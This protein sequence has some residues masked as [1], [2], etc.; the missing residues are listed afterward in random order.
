MELRRRAVLGLGLAVGGLAAAATAAQAAD[1]SP[2]AFELQGDP[3]RYREA[4]DDIRAYAA[5]HMAAYSLPGLTLTV[6]AP[7]GLTAFM[8][9]GYADVDRRT[10]VGP[11]QLFQIGSISKSFTALCIFRLMEAGKLKLSDDVGPLLPGVPLPAGATITVQHLL[12]H[13]SGLADDP[14]AWPRGGDQQLWRGYAPGSHW[15]YSNLGFA[16]LSTIVARLSGQPFPDALRALVLTPLGMTATKPAIL[17]ADRGLYATGY[18]PFAGNRDYPLGGRIAPG[19]WTEMVAGSGC[20]ASTAGDMARYAR[21]LIAAGQGHGA[22]LLSDANARRFTTATVEAPGWGAGGGQYANGLAVVD[23]GGRKLLHHTGG[24]LLFNSAIHLDPIA[25]VGAFASTNMGLFAYRP[26]DITA[27]ACA[28]MRAALAGAPPPQPKPAPPKL[29]DRAPYVGR[30]TARGGETLEVASDDLG[31]A[32]MHGGKRLVMSPS[33]PAAFTAVD[34]AATPLP[35]V[36][37][38]KAKAP[39][40]PAERAWWGET[41]Y[42]REGVAYSPPT[43]AALKALTGYYESDDPWRGSFRIMAQ[44]PALFIEGTT[45]VVPIGKGLYRTGD[46]AWS[47]ERLEL[48]RLRRRSAPAGDRLGRRLSAPAGLRPHGR[49]RGLLEIGDG[50]SLRS[51]RTDPASPIAHGRPPAPGRAG[52]R[53]GPGSPLGRKRPDPADGRGQTPGLDDPLG[54]AR[55]RQDHHRAPAGQGGRL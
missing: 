26:R 32:V 6:V 50:R 10:P 12:N 53:R 36:F 22:P 43:P 20:V 9:F 55:H 13:S 30:Y 25:G 49:R 27:Y 29:D 39:K 40:S 42:V 41:E 54:P 11:D 15:S 7:D 46:E 2:E 24:M 18:A 16:L 14:P 52:R 4:L 34:P 21:F 48:R 31:L 3:G 38:G 37:R 8:R 28:R 35:L 51:R 47:P 45:P 17:T 23:I 5:R 1:N 33:G 19:A 44:G